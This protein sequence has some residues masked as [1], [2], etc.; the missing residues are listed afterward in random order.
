MIKNASNKPPVPKSL[1]LQ[2]I[3]FD[4]SNELIA[5][6][7]RNG[8]IMAFSLNDFPTLKNATPKQR[9]NW[10]F[11]AGGYVIHW[12]EIDED[13][14]VKGFIKTFIKNQK[15]FIAKNESLVFAS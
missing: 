7:L 14:S 10:E 1:F 12:E 15:P 4:H 9:D 8:N 2:D 11:R 6:K 3:I 5:V 13:I